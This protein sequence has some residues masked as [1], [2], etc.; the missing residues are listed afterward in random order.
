M[1]IIYIHQYFNTPNMPGS[2]RSYEFA[3]SLIAEGAKVHMIT[4]NWQNKSNENYSM[5]EG[6]NIYWAPIKYSNEMGFFNRIKAFLSFVLFVFKVGYKIECDI[7]IASSTPLTVGVPALFF[8]IFKKVKLIFEVRDLWPQLPIATGDLKSKILISFSK[9]LERKIYYYSDE[10]IVLSDGMKTEIEKVISLK[11]KIN[12]ITNLCD[13]NNFR[14]NP[15]FGIDFRRQYLDIKDEPLIV[16]AGA[17]GKINNAIYLIEI[18][19]ESLQ[20]N[21]K[22]KF[23]LVGGGFQKKAILQKATALGLLNKNVFLKDYLPK[24]K[25]PNVLSAA[26]IVSSIFN[27]VIEMENNSA[28]KFFDGLAAGK[29]IMINYGGWQSDL[30]KKTGAGF[31]I[32][33]NNPKEASDIIND[34]INNQKSINSMKA[35]SKKLSESFTITLNCKKFINIVKKVYNEKKNI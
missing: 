20:Q 23:L 21:S 24:N 1:K 16:Y 22:L 7:V 19:N 6:I 3:K 8:K 34:L 9:Y 29:P 33:N 32:P 11:D 4:S 35:N 25:L 30:L 13:N 27:N 15:K 2:T 5:L 12:V 18:A 10:I 28:N 26:T 14:I 31:I 17:F